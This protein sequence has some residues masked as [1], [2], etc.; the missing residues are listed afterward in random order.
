[1]RTEIK[2]SSINI[3]RLGWLSYRAA[4]HVG[5]YERVRVGDI[6][7]AGEALQVRFHRPVPPRRLSDGF[8]FGTRRRPGEAYSAAVTHARAKLVGREGLDETSLVPHQGGRP[9]TEEEIIDRSILW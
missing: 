4:V 8:Q 3:D 7:G 1:M 6:D 9:L 2:I 5:E